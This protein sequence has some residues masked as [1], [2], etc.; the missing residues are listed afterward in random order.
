M[1][2]VRS[3][4]HASSKQFDYITR[5][6]ILWGIFA[7]IEFSIGINYQRERGSLQLIIKCDLTSKP[8]KKWNREIQLL[9]DWIFDGIVWVLRCP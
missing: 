2:M 8:T 3:H 4:V 9:F 7:I 1:I 6:K 5:T